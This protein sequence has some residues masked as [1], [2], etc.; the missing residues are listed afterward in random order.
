VERPKLPKGGT[1]EMKGA[2]VKRRAKRKRP[3][4]KKYRST[5]WVAGKGFVGGVDDMGFA[6]KG[7]S[8]IK[9]P[10][11][12]KRKRLVEGE[13]PTG[14]KTVPTRNEELTA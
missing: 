10:K 3:G 5:A 12:G 4:A 14:T 13:R 2:K 8:P 6:G 1:G 11:E 9:N 7:R